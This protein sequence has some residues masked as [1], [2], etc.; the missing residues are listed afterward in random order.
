[1]KLIDNGIRVTVRMTPEMVGMGGKR[2]KKKD[3]EFLKLTFFKL[4]NRDLI[5]LK[6]SE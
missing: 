4:K 1:M 6:I 3:E 5:Y 2:K